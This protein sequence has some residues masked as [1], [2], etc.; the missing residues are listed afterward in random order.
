[1]YRLFAITLAAAFIPSLASAQSMAA[2]ITGRVSDPSKA[3][4]VNAK[5]V[6]ISAATDIHYETATNMS[7]EYSLA[8]LP[9][10]TYTIEIEKPGFKKLIKPSVTLHVGD[11]LQI[12]FEMIVGSMSQSVT[13]KS[14]APLLNTE[15]AALSTVVDRTFV[16]NMPLN[17]RSFQSLI[18]LT[19]GQVSVPAYYTGTGQ[20]AVNGQRSDAN[21]FFIDGVSANIGTTQGAN[22]NLGAQAAGVAPATS[23]N[24]GYNNLVSIDDLQEYKI[25]TSTFAPEYGRVPGAQLAIVTRSGTNDFHGNLFEYLRNEVF[26]SRDYFAALNGLPKPKEK[27]ND[28]G[29]TL[30]G[31]I[32]RNKLFFFLSYE[33]LR[34]RVP[35]TR[36][37]I[38]PSTSLRASAI[39]AVA[40]MLKAY[41]LPTKD[42][43]PGVPIATAVSTFSDPSTLDATSLRLDYTATSKLS[44]FVRGDYGPS[45]GAQ[46]GAYGV[47]T[48]STLSHNVAD[49]DTTTAGATWLISPRLLNDFRVNLSHTKGATTVEPTNFGGATPPSASYLFSPNPNA[50]F[51][52]AGLTLFMLDGSSGYSVGQD[53]TNRQKQLNLVDS[54]S[55]SRGSHNFKFGVV[56]RHLWPIN[57]H[58]QW[59]VL[60]YGNSFA[61]LAQGE[62]FEGRVDT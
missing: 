15:S 29:G 12:D 13:V 23:N 20:F 9:L 11:E 57:G 28:F 36:T 22:F 17:G 51:G 50:S 39:P 8:N 45:N 54:L 59:A 27:Q 41:P 46:Y 21:Y 5:V 10:G 18:A 19:P 7:G 49:V 2:L 44:F 24:G 47:Y 35:F 4:I 34:L 32:L 43:V 53:Q 26:D 56:Y 58:A 16:E 60:Y 37:E 48:S 40:P 33:G 3:L 38:V 42:D 31:P 52:N 6:A 25:Q 30:G 61:E 55:W 14:G 62:I 1:M